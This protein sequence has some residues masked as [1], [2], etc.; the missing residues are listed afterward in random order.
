MESEELNIYIYYEQN[1]NSLQELINERSRFEN[2][3]YDYL[4]EPLIVID[5][6]FWE[7]VQVGYNKIK[8]LQDIV[9]EDTCFICTDK[10]INFKNMKCCNQKM[11]NGCCYTWFEKSVKCPYCQ[12]DL[13]EFDK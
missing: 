11:C 12:Q 4:L 9:T 6:S 5:E 8:E 1:G 13:R 2:Y 10:H 3:L 7:P